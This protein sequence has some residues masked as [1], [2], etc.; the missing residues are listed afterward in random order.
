[1]VS[2]VIEA[3]VT[4]HSAK[5]PV[6]HEILEVIYPEFAD[7]RLELFARGSREGWDTWGNQAEETPAAD[8]CGAFATSGAECH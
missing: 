6:V 2:S 8:G 5:P 7:E 4:K 1:M 3:P